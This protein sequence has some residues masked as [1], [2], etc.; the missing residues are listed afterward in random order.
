MSGIVIEGHCPECGGP[1]RAELWDR[2][3][4]C[5]YCESL[6][7]F[8]RDDTRDVYAVSDGESGAAHL[9][10]ILVRHELEAYRA[11]RAARYASAG[12]LAMEPLFGDTDLVQFAEHLRGQFELR[13]QVDFFVPYWLRESAVA[14]AVL[15][16][17]GVA[18]ESYLQLFHTEQLS[19][20]YDE[21]A[22]HL[23]D[24][25]LKI[26]GLRLERLTNRHLDLAA[27]RFRYW[28]SFREPAI[29]SLPRVCG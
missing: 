6:L 22:F 24:R 25:G 14:E 11:R 19:R 13:L 5:E 27:G 12:P 17:R 9:L 8:A 15:G 10:E 20:G 4:V 1:Y 28:R 2:T 23:R 29:E 16:R 21:R 3:H 7:A 18:K 26:G